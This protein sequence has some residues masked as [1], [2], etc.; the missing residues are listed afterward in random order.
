MNRISKIINEEIDKLSLD[1]I[2]QY[3]IKHFDL[4]NVI[5]PASIPIE[6][7]NIRLFHQTNK[8]NFENI[9]K[10]G[11]IK[12][13]KSTG[14]AMR[15]PIAIWGHEKGFYGSPKEHYSIEYQLP[16]NQQD[17]GRIYRDVRAD[18]IIAFHD[19]ILHYIKEYVLKKR[20]LSNI[21][22]DL[23]FFLGFGKIRDNSREY[24]MYLIANAIT[25]MYE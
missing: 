13:D 25:N 17:V 7:G 5:E 9:K 2:Q 16:E 22:D 15:E 12:I 20:Y 24:A 4:N 19:P 10:D 11:S 21:A 3:L 18:E 1:N 8:E 14:K 23:D 6:N